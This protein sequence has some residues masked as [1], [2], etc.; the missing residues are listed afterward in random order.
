MDILHGIE[1][2][3]LALRQSPPAGDIMRIAQPGA[4]I[5][6]AM[7]RPL[8]TPAFKPLITDI[9]LQAGDS[10]ADPAALYTQIVVDKARLTRHIGQTLQTRGQVLL[11]ELLH[12]LPLQQRL[13]GLVTYL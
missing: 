11:Y 9:E 8:F 1:S 6:L 12:S 10:D 5:E 13:L 7:E 2:K 3:A 4:A